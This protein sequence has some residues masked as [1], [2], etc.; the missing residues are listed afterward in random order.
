M[1]F[2]ANLLEDQNSKRFVSSVFKD[3]NKTLTEFGKNLPKGSKNEA[4]KELKDSLSGRVDN[5]IIKSFAT[6]TNPNYT[7]DVLVRQNAKSW[8]L[9]NVV[10]KNRDLREV[11]KKMYG[12][13]NVNHME[14]YAD[15][16]VIRAEQRYPIKILQ[17]IGS[18][19]LRMDKF[20][21]LKT[22]EELPDAIKKLLGEE[23]DLRSQ[24]LFTVTDAVTTTANKKGFDRIAE[25]G[26]RNGWLFDSVDAAKTKFVNPV[27]I[28]EIKNLGSMSSE[29]E[30][31]YTSPE[32][33]KIL[34][35]TG[36]PLDV[37][38]KIPVIRQLLQATSLSRY[39]NLLLTANASKNCLTS[40]SIFSLVEWTLE[41][42][43]IID[44]QMLIYLKAGKY[45]R[46]LVQ[47][48]PRYVEKLVG[49]GVYDENIVA[50]ELKAVFR[51]LKDGK[52]NYRTRVV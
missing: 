49:L 43:N 8:V 45:G 35:D 16:L 25:I 52:I 1:K 31:L 15:D 14:K 11:A 36:T 30:K 32:L 6:F 51:N 28:G 7:P 40:A 41:N 18:K 23:K 4:I 26:K 44:L 48:L 46:P 20:K 3:I 22:G 39:E 27:Q 17:D 24:V 13:A 33:R 42:P 12:G 29:L 21:F 5:Y 19:E 34:T 47:H 2:K 50:Q 38:T 10:S 37:L 9:K